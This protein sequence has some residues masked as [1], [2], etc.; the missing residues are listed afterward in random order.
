MLEISL[1]S[2]FAQRKL[3][4]ELSET[5][6]GF[7]LKLLFYFVALLKYTAH[8]QCLHLCL[9][10]MQKVT[11]VVAHVGVYGGVST[12]RPIY[13]VMIV[14]GYASLTYILIAPTNR[15]RDNK[16]YPCTFLTSWF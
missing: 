5:V 11:G 2:F 9:V 13:D 8:R 12:K 6:G 10:Y 7:Y 3:S 4:F 16:V 14:H 1:G 15:S